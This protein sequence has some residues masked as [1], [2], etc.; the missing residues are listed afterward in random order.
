MQSIKCVSYIPVKIIVNF[1]SVETNKKTTSKRQ[2]F[3]GQYMLRC[4]Q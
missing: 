1:H 3:L 2:A 4:N